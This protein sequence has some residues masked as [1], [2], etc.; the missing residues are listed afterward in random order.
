MEK[1]WKQKRPFIDV[2][3][4]S[5]L[6]IHQVSSWG[7][8][9]LVDP[10]AKLDAG[11]I[12]VVQVTAGDLKEPFLSS[13]TQRVLSQEE[14]VKELKVAQ[15]SLNSKESAEAWATLVEKSQE[16]IGI[17]YAGLTIDVKEDIG[18][19]GWAAVRRVVMD[20][21]PP[22][23]CMLVSEL[24]ST[25]SGKREDMMAIWEVILDWRVKNQSGGS[26]D[27][28]SWALAMK[29]WLPNHLL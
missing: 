2:S 9:L 28:D 29:R 26:V 3:C 23:S 21:L 17:G 22:R 6:E 10:E 4:S 14:K 8:L 5:C 24:G 1:I 12:S 25:G 13:L 15:V 16:T 7:F 19:E 11:E 20:L 18:A 27:F